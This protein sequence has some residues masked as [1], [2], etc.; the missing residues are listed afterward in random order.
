MKM[1]RSSKL[2]YQKLVKE[3]FGKSLL[4][5]IDEYT[6]VSKHSSV[7]DTVFTPCGRVRP[8]FCQVSTLSSVFIQVIGQTRQAKIG[9]LV[10][11]L[12]RPNPQG[13]EI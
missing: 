8:I 7:P 11:S 5:V 2:R 12:I 4:L 13:E 3:Y 6:K 9:K 1:L 10:R